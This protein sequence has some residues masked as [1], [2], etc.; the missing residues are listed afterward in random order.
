MS[1]LLLGPTEFNL[2]TNL[3]E[4]ETASE[5]R[6]AEHNILGGPI[7]YEAV[8]DGKHEVTLSGVI[9]PERI[10]TDGGVTKLYLAKKGQTPLP[11]FRGDFSP[12]GWVIIRKISHK[13]IKIS[14]AGQG[15]KINFTANIAFV[16][17]PTGTGIAQ[18][19]LRILT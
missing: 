8:G 19:I 10:G 14:H 7:V 15:R 18:R 17:Q 9:Y 3:Q 16:S 4:I 5:A 13:E 2:I 1:S 6:F 11:F 12:F